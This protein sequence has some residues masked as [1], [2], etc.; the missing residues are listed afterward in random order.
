MFLKKDTK[1]NRKFVHWYLVT[2]VS[3]FKNEHVKLYICNREID[4]ETTILPRS[5]VSCASAPTAFVKTEKP[6]G[7]VQSRKCKEWGL[8]NLFC[9]Q[10]RNKYISMR[11]QIR[12]RLMF[13]TTNTNNRLSKRWICNRIEKQATHFSYIGHCTTSHCT[14]KCYV[15]QGTI[16]TKMAL[17]SSIRLVQWKCIG[18]ST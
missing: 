17:S 13:F 1:V 16:G 15:I 18:I 8:G 11:S 10:M 3:F 4:K 6:K 5:S 7:S 14:T 12:I 2:L 9:F